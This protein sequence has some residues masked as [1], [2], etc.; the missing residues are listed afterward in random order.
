ME[1]YREEG[2]G[3]TNSLIKELKKVKN[4]DELLI[5]TP[6]LKKLFKQLADL[7]VAAHQYREK[8]PTLEIPELSTTAHT[9]NEQLRSE[10]NRIYLIEG[11]REVIE[12]CQEEALPIGFL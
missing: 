3:I 7:I 5:G 4:R 2:E 12:K 8:H 6:R 10:L 9:L 11:G 1:D